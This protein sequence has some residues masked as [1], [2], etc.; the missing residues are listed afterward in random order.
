[1]EKTILNFYLKKK[2]MQSSKK[3]KNLEVMSKVYKL[4]IHGDSMV[5][6]ME[7][8][9]VEWPP[10]TGLQD[11]KEMIASRKRIF[12]YRQNIRICYTGKYR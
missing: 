4:R 3:K 9:A 10:L 6:T 7:T 1:M 5:G 12:G 8:F 2:T 11:L